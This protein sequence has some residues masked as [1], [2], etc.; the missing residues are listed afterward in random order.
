MAISGS[1]RV[2]M[3]GMMIIMM[4]MLMMLTMI[5]RVVVMVMILLREALG[6]DTGYTAQ[7]MTKR[8][9]TFLLWMLR[10]NRMTAVLSVS[11]RSTRCLV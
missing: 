1:V 2:R 10:A 6:K 3:I 11:R 7:M 4:T 9:M 8:T 5:V